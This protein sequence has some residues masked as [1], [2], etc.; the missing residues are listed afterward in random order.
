MLKLS[1]SLGCWLNLNKFI[2]RA[3]AVNVPKLRHL[4][5]SVCNE[6]LDILNIVLAWE[7]AHILL[8]ESVHLDHGL[9]K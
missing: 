3:G 1:Y 4:I 7:F 5:L 8:Y 9:A 6:P 2:Q